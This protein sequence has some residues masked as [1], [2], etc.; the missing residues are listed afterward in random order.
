MN[1]CNMLLG[2]I[3]WSGSISVIVLLFSLLVTGLILLENYRLRG[4]LWPVD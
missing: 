3:V 1:L 2:L 4:M